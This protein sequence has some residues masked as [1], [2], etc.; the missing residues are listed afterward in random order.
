MNIDWNSKVLS[1]LNPVIENLQTINLNLDQ[2]MNVADWIAYE[3]FPPPEQNI[4]KNNPDEFIR[5]TMLINTLN[6]AF[7][8]FENSTKYEII[9]EGKVLSDSE[10]MFV[11]IQEAISSGLQLYNGNVLSD[12]DDK[13]LKNI[14]KGNIEMPMMSERLDILLNVGAKLSDDYEGDWMNFINAGPKKLYDNGEGL[15]ERL[16]SEF[17]RFDDTSQYA[18]KYNVHFYKLAQLAFWG[19]HAELAGTGDFYI[20]DMQSMSAFADYIVPVALEVMKIV[21]YSE[22]LRNKITNGEII[23]R[24]SL[25]E[26][27]IRSTSLYITAKLTEEINKRRPAEKSIII[28]QLD[29]RL[30]KQYHATHR[31]HHLTIT[32]MY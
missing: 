10:A 5:T 24:D 2:I 29:Y 26:I 20:E 22:E 30:W 19:I 32:T 17:P 9:R 11:Q 15:I 25:E 28:P 8:D 14:F 7:T 4:S 1:S 27:E 23:A 13:Q 6:F 21:E 12:L 18:E 31:P 16:T 3:D